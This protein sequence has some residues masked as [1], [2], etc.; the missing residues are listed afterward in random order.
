MES[1]CD[2]GKREGEGGWAKEKEKGDGKRLC[3]STQ[4]LY[5][6]GSNCVKEEAKE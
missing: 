1:L 6:G 2:G 4:G 3:V 5:E